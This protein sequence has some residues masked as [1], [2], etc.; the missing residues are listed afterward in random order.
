MKVNSHYPRTRVSKTIRA[1]SMPRMSGSNH[2]IKHQSRVATR[3]QDRQGHTTSPQLSTQ[4]ASTSTSQ[5]EY[6]DLIDS[7]SATKPLPKILML[8]GLVLT[9]TWPQNY[10]GISTSDNTIFSTQLYWESQLQLSFTGY[11]HYLAKQ[12]IH[13]F[14]PE[15]RFFDKYLGFFCL[16]EN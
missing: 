2:R 7:M 16:F 15:K 13:F 8:H 11:D 9:L 5:L 6:L 12:N 1:L 14:I 4:S 3:S 10:H